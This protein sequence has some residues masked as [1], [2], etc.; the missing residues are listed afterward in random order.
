MFKKRRKRKPAGKKLAKIVRFGMVKYVWVP[1]K[2][3]KKWQ[4]SIA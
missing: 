4:R 3:K 2:S 1:I